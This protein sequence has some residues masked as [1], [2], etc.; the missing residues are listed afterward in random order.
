MTKTLL[1]STF[2][3]TG[4]LS[5]AQNVNVPDANFKAYLVGNTAI[6]TNADSEIQVS[7]AAAFT[8]NIFANNLN[9][10]DITGIEAFTSL[11]GLYCRNNNIG[12][13]DISANAA[14]TYVDCQN[15]G[16]SSLD[17]SM[18]TALEGVDCSLNSL[19]S[20]DA[21]Y[22]SNLTAI[23]CGNNDLTALDVSNNPLL[24]NFSCDNNDLTSLDVSNHTSLLY[25][26]CH[27]NELT[28]IDVSNCPVLA[29][30]SCS[31][32][33]LTS[34]DVSNNT[35]LGALYCSVNSIQ[36]LDVSANASLQ[37]VRCDDN[38]LYT[39]NVKNG[40]N[41][42][43]TTFF[44]STNPNLTCIEVDD[45]AYSTST[46]TNIDA[47][48]N[49]SNDCN[50]NL[51]IDEQTASTPSIAIYPNPVASQLHIQVEPE[52]KIESVN[53]IDTFGRTITRNLNSN[54]I[55]VSELT[56]GIYF[57]Q[58]KTK[59]GIVSKKFTKK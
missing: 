16:I 20:L 55:N 25:F 45:A 21:S 1:L 49:F 53:I 29:H 28:S 19:T 33:D 38:N 10:S 27:F 5:T 35:A 41:V 17:L 7:E 30:F 23:N 22:N 31:G 13:L 18:N 32:N 6:N 26:V 50:Y 24:S 15:T 36:N 48:A 51:G 11:T 4:L 43:F 44:S 42:N 39:L 47:N 12:T 8:G 14:L 52:V 40:N 3:L 57:V 59:R 54:T 37:V 46:W 56:E 58:I 9:I 34:L 2:L